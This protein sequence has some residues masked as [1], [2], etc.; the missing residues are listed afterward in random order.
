MCILYY[1]LDSIWINV[2]LLLTGP[3]E[4]NTR[5]IFNINIKISIPQNST[6]N[7]IPLAAK[8]IQFNVGMACGM[9]L[10]WQIAGW[11]DGLY[12]DVMGLYGCGKVKVVIDTNKSSFHIDGLVQDCSISH[13]LAMEILLS[14]TKPSIC[15]LL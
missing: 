15:D 6:E 7:I 10:M 3:S 13:V 9:C 8:L 4:T 12:S 14:F 11:D 5:E 1:R 2:D